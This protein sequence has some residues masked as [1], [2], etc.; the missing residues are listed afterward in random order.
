M[1]RIGPRA[2]NNVDGF[3]SLG[4]ETFRPLRHLEGAIGTTLLPFGGGER[5]CL[6]KALAELEIQLM[7]EGL[8]RQLQLQLTADQHLD[9]QLL[10][11][12][13]PRDDLLV[14]ATRMDS[15]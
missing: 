6:G 2:L 4:L 7:V 5:A 12:P 13:A 10:P 14:R 3:A 1:R 8:L 15:F 9:L 11:N